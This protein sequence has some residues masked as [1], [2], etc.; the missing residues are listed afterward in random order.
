MMR[1]HPLLFAFIPLKHRKIRD[2]DEP[3]IFRWIAAFPEN[4]VSLRI[5]LCQR[6]PQQS[7]RRINRAFRGRNLSV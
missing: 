1:G 4:S 6:Q 5:F 2:P 3:K 7:R